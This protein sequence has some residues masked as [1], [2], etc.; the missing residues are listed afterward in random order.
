MRH[1]A[2]RES[3]SPARW[4]RRLFRLTLMTFIVYQVVTILFVQSV[5]QKSVAMEP[6]LEAGERF[7]ALPLGYGPRVRLFGLVLPGFRQPRR[8]DLALVR[9]GYVVE[10]GFAGRLAD[11]FVRFFTLEHRRVD[12]GAGWDSSLQIKRVI[13][14]PG[15][16]V[17][18][19]RFIAYVRPP[20]RHE[21]VDEFALAGREYELLTEDRPGDWE[22]LDPFGA[23]LE[24]ITLGKG[25]YFVL[26][27]HRTIGFDS[28]HWGAIGRADL[29]TQ[30]SI[31][32]WPLRRFGRP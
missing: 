9:P 21:F 26:S 10:P 30:I 23:A 4:L 7:F 32:F 20:D 29:V 24:S 12:D 31:R 13:G 6:T 18:I 1:T 25:E 28:R 3:A 19:E 27:D 17:R 8:G 14:L 16:T 22:P 15:D 5:V 11:P 2:Y